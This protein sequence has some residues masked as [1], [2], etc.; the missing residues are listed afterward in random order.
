MLIRPLALQDAP[1]YRLLRLRGFQ[2]HPDAFNSSYEEQSQEPLSAMEKRI[3]QA[4]ASPREIMLGAFD[5]AGV[6]MGA[7]AL[8]V[9]RRIK[10][11]HKGWVYGM[12]VPTE[13]AGKGIGRALLTELIRRARQHGAFDH[14]HLT[15]TA[16]NLRAVR[17]YESVGFVAGGTEVRAI[18]T[19]G[20]YYDKLHMALLL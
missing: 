14:L 16:T 1:A 3:E 7:V 12:Y 6:Q 5:D 9:E 20:Q 19:G 10:L 8:S 13:H 4:L 18:K 15:V 17:L 2:E 11:Q